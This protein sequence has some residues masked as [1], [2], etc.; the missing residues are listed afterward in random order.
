TQLV[1]GKE[2][3]ILRIG[4][5]ALLVSSLLIATPVELPLL[6]RDKSAPPKPV[7]QPEPP[8]ITRII[9]RIIA[10]E[11]QTRTKLQDYSPRIETYLQYY[12]PEPELGD[13]A[14][15]DD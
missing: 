6:G 2:M 9:Y 12:K 7:E 8:E 13:V 1:G 14:T 15:N 10:N 3:S 4:R 11:W 5:T